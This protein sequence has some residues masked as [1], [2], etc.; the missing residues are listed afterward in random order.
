MAKQGIITAPSGA[1]ANMRTLGDPSPATDTLAGVIRTA[2]G[3]VSALKGVILNFRRG[4]AVVVPTG[5]ADPAPGGAVLYGTFT[6]DDPTKASSPFTFAPEAGI[7]AGIVAGFEAVVAARKPSMSVES[8][9]NAL[10][11]LD[12]EG[13]VD[14]G[15]N[16]LVHYDQADGEIKVVG[17]AA[18]DVYDA[19]G[20]YAEDAAF[21]RTVAATGGSQ[22]G[23]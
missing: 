17:S 4:E 12:A 10:E 8:L 22:F 1:D 11:D 9:T 23:E 18:L 20:A 19:P 15:K 13:A 21:V 16:L 6:K 2:L 5:Y 7:D 3:L 14:P